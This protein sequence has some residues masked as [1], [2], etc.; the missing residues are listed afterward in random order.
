[1]KRFLIRLLCMV[2]AV[3]LLLRWDMY[4][5][6]PPVT[7]KNR[8][9]MYMLD[10]GEADCF[11]LMQGD[12]TMLVDAGDPTTADYVVSTLAEM[13]I[14]RLD[15]VLLTH[16]HTDHIGGMKR[17]LESFD[18][19]HYLYMPVTNG[20]SSRTLLHQRVD[21][22]L[23]QKQITVQSLTN[24]ATF[25]LGDARVT[26][27]PSLGTD[28]DAN[29]CSAICR[30]DYSGQR[31]LLTGDASAERLHALC[32]EGFD[33]KADVWKIGHHGS[34]KSVDRASIKAVGAKTAL[35]SCDD[36]TLTGHP[37]ASTVALLEAASVDIVRTD[38]HGTTRVVI[39][40]GDTE[41]YTERV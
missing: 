22:V 38:L 19:G 11:L 35:I 7:S 36:P 12:E 1:M 39:E 3:G 16:P 31:V 21:A 13:G 20:D 40:D 32:E 2:C 4:T 30:V 14:E 5:T 15:Y 27:F 26:I 18:V 33:I 28:S 6:A 25:S 37:A 24:G 41:V 34:E 8:L 29:D 17:V 10:V 23:A 9:T